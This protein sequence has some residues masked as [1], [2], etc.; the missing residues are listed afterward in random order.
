MRVLITGGTGFVGSHAVAAVAAAGH[1]IRLLIRS[2]DR[3]TRAL[4]PHGISAVDTVLGDVNDADS[5]RDAISG[6]DALIHAGSMYSLDRRQAASVLRTNVQGTRNVLEAAASAGLDPIIHISSMAAFCD[7]DGVLS[8]DTEPGNPPGFYF[9]SK[10][11]SD[12]TAREFQ[13]KGLPVVIIYPPMVWG[14]HD[15]HLGETCLNAINLLKG[16]YRLSLD[17]GMIVCDV[18]DVAQLIAASLQSGRGPRRYLVPAVSVGIQAW[19]DRFNAITGRKLR[20]TMLPAGLSLAM[21]RACDALQPLMP[22]RLPLESQG[23]WFVSRFRN[24]QGWDDA[25]TIAEF[26]IALPDIDRTFADTIRWLYE[27]GHLPAKLVGRI[28]EGAA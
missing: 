14:P 13:A 2:M 9:R 8:P 6:C 21:A 27:Q 1:E 23:I 3:V 24:W 18:R 22:F 11:D 20:T 25:S 15:P 28:A 16:A 7:R 10:A 12:R 19:F 4:A 26:G 5:V 17:G